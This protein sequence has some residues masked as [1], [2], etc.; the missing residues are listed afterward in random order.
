[1]NK[2]FDEA[3]MTLDILVRIIILL[4]QSLGPSGGIKLVPTVQSFIIRI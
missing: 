3:L 4:V 2:L 1:M